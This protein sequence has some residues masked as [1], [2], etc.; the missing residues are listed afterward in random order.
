MAR[1]LAFSI[2]ALAALGHAIPKHNLPKHNLPKK[3]YAEL[4][5]P[6]NKGKEMRATYLLIRCKSKDRSLPC[7][8]GQP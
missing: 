3:G 7:P 8:D 2:L 6:T 4:Q 1:P 5:Q